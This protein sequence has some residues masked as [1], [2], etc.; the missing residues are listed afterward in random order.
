MFTN[1][2]NRWRL[3]PDGEP[4]MTHSSGLLPVRRDGVPAMLKIALSEEERAG[5]LLMSW[6]NGDGAAKVLARGDDAILLERAEGRRSLTEFARQGR[7]EEACRI[8]CH[9]VAKLH[10]PRGE[11]PPGLVSLQEWFCELEPAAAK[12]GGIL[13]KAA[14]TSR[15]LLASPRDKVVLHGDVHHDN[16]LDFGTRGWLAIDPKGL[17]GERGFDYANIF[18]NPDLE[19]A[20][21]A[22]SL[23]PRATTIAEVS[24][25]ER[26]RLLQWALAYAG[27]RAA[28]SISDGQK[29]EPLLTVAEAAAAELAK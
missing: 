11:P 14:A 28:W 12:H 15:L 25:L 4:I 18:P 9:A 19:A 20:A 16:I 7:D 22:G 26:T 17:F 5:G 23:A 8:I 2:L 1:Y 10:A 21:A 3:T 13:M 6:W 27:L 24:G 29:P